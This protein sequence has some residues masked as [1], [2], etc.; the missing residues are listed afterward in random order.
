M[1]GKKKKSKAADDNAEKEPEKPPP[2]II[3][4]WIRIEFKLLN[5]KF[6]NFS[7]KFFENTNVFTIKRLLREKHGRI[8]DLKLCFHSFT[9][10]NEVLDEML[11]LLEC[12]LKGHPVGHAVTPE[13]KE[14]EEKNIPVVQCFYDFKPANYSDPVLLYFR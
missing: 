13:E 4:N 2:P 12:G 6:M 1:G 11:T 10:S 5:W 7:M 3:E 8:D 14:L 9:D